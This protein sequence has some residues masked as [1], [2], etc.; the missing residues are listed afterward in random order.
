MNYQGPAVVVV[1]CVTKDE[2]FYP[3][4]HNLVGRAGCDKGVCTMYINQNTMKCEFENLGIQ[5]VRK[6]DIAEALDQ[7]QQI[8]VDPFRSKFHSLLAR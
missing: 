7:R 8:K 6:R 2:P 5:C 1:S 4:P 3:H